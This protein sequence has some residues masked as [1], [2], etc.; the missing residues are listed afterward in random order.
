MRDNGDDRLNRLIAAARSGGMESS[1]LEEHFEIRLMARI[2]ERKTMGQPWYL[3][4]W[5]MLPG[6]AVATLL[7]AAC[8]IALNP[9]RSSDLFA[10]ITGGTEDRITISYLAGE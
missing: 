5:R 6:F 8:S 3:L 1:P 10:G 4:A 7:T 2:A 9:S